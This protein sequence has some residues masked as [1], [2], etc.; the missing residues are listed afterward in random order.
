MVVAPAYFLMKTAVEGRSGFRVHM[1]EVP[2]THKFCP[3]RG[4]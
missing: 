3:T 1:L 4:P 2:H